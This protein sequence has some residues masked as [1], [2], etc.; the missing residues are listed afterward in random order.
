[1]A[2]NHLLDNFFSKEDLVRFAMNGEKL[3]SGVKLQII[4]RPVF[5]AALH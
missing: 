4:L 1:V 5:M 2:A 3:A